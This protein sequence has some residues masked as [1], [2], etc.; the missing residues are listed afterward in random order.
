MPMG[1][2]PL[3]FVF[4]DSGAGEAVT[5]QPCPTCV[6]RMR[7]PLWLAGQHFGNW[8][9]I[10]ETPIKRTLPSGSK[11]CYWLCRCICGRIREVQSTSL[12]RGITT[13]C[14]CVGGTPRH[15]F[16]GLSKKT[17]EYRVWMGMRERCNNSNSVGYKYYGEKGITVCKRWD[18]F[19][20]FMEDMGSRPNGMTLD[21]INPFGNYEPSNCRW[22][23][24]KTQALNKRAH[25]Q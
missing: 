1:L 24:W 12:K 13:S 2:P 3:L 10:G 5:S 21:R 23:S 16:H 20:A 17:P 22:A 25:W 9:V 4:Y 15:E 6:T 11:R 14:G 19:T 7:T 8:S 18:S